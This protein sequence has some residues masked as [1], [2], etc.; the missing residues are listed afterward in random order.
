VL[1]DAQRREVA[2]SLAALAHDPNMRIRRAI[3]DDLAQ[4]ELPDAKARLD[5][6]A[7]SELD[8]RVLILVQ[9]E[10]RELR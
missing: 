10:L 9:D 8:G 4:L 5:A 1:S 6:L 7:R 3:I 2:A